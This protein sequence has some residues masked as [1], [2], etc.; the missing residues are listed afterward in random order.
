MILVVEDSDDDV[1]LLR[2]AFRAAGIPNPVVAV[3]SGQ[4]ALDYLEGTGKYRTRVDFPLPGL[5]LLDLKMPAMDGFDVLKWIRGRPEF[6]VIPIIV[7]TSSND[8]KDIKR[9]YTLGANSYIAKEIDFADTIGI[10]RLLKDYWLGLNKA[11]QATRPETKAGTPD[12]P[13]A[14]GVQPP[15]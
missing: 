9:A 1:A 12:G 15:R 10:S 3:S 11:Y 4:E 13:D 7:L 2:R 5:I 14:G 6:S 8:V